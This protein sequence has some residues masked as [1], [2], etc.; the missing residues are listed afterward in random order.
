MI[1]KS[2]ELLLQSSRSRIKLSC[3]LRDN[4]TRCLERSMK[5]IVQS[6]QLLA[7]SEALL[8]Y[9]EYAEY[10]EAEGPKPKPRVAQCA[11]SLPAIISNQ[12]FDY[13]FVSVDG[14]HYCECAFRN[15][16]LLYGGSP[17]TFEACQFH[18]CRFQFS[19]A[20]GRTVQFLD[21]FGLLDE[22]T[23]DEAC[24]DSDDSIVGFVN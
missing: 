17:V 19:G 20:A 13:E 3:Y 1:D 6:R 4:T 24:C 16:T 7:N 21:C 12:D 14:K 11:T 15:C 2:I 22:Q 9:P 23:P 5:A 18:G 8:S 10:L